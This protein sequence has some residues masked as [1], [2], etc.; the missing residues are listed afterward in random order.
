[1][2]VIYSRIFH[3]DVQTYMPFL[4]TGYV[5]W[6]LIAQVLNES[7]GA[8][9]EGVSIIKQV[10]LPYAIYVLRVVWRNFI[11]F[12]HTIVI[13]VPVALFFHVVP[14]V[15]IFLVIPALLLLL[16]NLT[17]VALT[18]AILGT[19]YRDIPP[20]VATATQILLFATPIMWPASTLGEATWIAEINPLYHLIELVRAPLLG[21][22]PSMLSWAV[23]IGVAVA[24][25]A[26][27]LLLLTRASR[28]LV[29]WL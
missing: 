14:S 24:G 12:L 4:T 2:G 29:F 17:W 9:Q 13:F 1:L 16:I 23:A 20:I 10:R 5:T 6:G 15:R 28:R 8:F 19:R 21:N 3:I 22:A 18:L 27:S 7:C 26:V 25:T 11:V